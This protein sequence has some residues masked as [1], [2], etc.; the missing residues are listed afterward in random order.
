MSHN[1]F[2]IWDMELAAKLRQLRDKRGVSEREVSRAISKTAPEHKA[3][4]T[5]VGRWFSGTGMPSFVQAV[6]LANYFGVP[7]SYLA[8]DD[9]AS[10]P[11]EL[12]EDEAIVLRFYRIL[13]RTK[14]I[15]EELAV[16]GMSSM[17]ASES[18]GS[19]EPPA[20]GSAPVPGPPPG[21]DPTFRWP[22]APRDPLDGIIVRKPVESA[23]EAEK[24]AGSPPRTRRK[25]QV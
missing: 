19:S 18:K 13:K 17:G 25:R 15:D 21:V 24:S 11:A 12:P 2:H 16:A 14:G 6:E 7:I 4:P 1:L 9:A 8:Y 20:R 22:V 23:K 3:S 5:T 10:A